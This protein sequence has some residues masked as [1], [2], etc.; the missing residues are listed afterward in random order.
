MH[1]GVHSMDRQKAFP[2]C[3]CE[4]VAADPH[5]PWHGNH[6]S[7]IRGMSRLPYHAIAEPT[8]TKLGSLGVQLLSTFYML[9]RIKN[10][11]CNRF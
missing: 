6:K 3:G 4:Y 9:C 1:F 8:G 7:C 10:A 11:V 5:C 2:Q